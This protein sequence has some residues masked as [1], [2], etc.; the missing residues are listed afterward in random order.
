MGISLPVVSAG[1]HRDPAQP[2][3]RLKH[4]Q[5]A[6]SSITP[7]LGSCT[8]TQKKNKT[9]K[10]SQFGNTAGSL[11]NERARGGERAS[12]KSLLVS[13]ISF[14]IAV[15]CRKQQQSRDFLQMFLVTNIPP[16]LTTDSILLLSLHLSFYASVSPQEEAVQLSKKNA[17][18]V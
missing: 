3:R 10:N 18:A 14:L 9:K 6:F 13:T 12:S 2:H 5:E 8:P 7:W 4:H 17:T 11:E 1:T 15:A 16:L